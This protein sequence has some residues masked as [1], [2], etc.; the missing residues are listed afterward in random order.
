VT[1]L[2]TKVTIY[3][4]SQVLLCVILFLHQ[5]MVMFVAR[6]SALIFI[7]E[8]KFSQMSE[9][10]RRRNLHISDYLPN[11]AAKSVDDSGASKAKEEEVKRASAVE[12]QANEGG[13]RVQLFRISYRNLP[14]ET[15]NNTTFYLFLAVMVLALLNFPRLA[16]VA[17]FW[18][19]VGSIVCP[20]IVIV[21][22]GCFY[23][24]VK[25]EM[26]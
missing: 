10:L 25:K 20:L 14:P 24:Q 7:D 8:K 23:Y 18:A 6:E 4:L 11:N 22:P 26:E 12:G 2:K 21:I 5:Y 1:P 13:S 19:V 16:F 3:D 9:M 17:K 15:K